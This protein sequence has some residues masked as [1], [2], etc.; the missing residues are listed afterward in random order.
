MSR[1]AELQQ[2][3]QRCVLDPPT[4]LAQPWVRAGGCAPPERQLGAYVHAYRARLKEVLE[5]DYPALH[6]ALGDTAFDALAG[7]YLRACPSRHFSLRAFGAGLAA[8]LAGQRADREH[9]WLAELA[10]FEWTLGLTFDAADAQPAHVA[11][12]AAVAAADWPA[13]RLDCHPSVQR[14]QL[15]WNVPELWG[16]LTA[17]E[18]SMPDPIAGEPVSW[19]IWRQELRTRF[20]SL[21]PDEAAALDALGAGADFSGLCL[22]LARWHEESDVPLRAATLVKQWIAEG[23]ISRIRAA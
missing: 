1:L 5:L 6:Q 12:M 9:P 3:F 2:A 21:Q 11:D 14:L 17:P 15:S 8:H 10:R 19:L 7:S 4:P 13:L 20:R 23:L 16:A 18:P 22:C